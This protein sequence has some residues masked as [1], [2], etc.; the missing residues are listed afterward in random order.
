M[1][2]TRD[3]RAALCEHADADIAAF[4]TSVETGRVGVVHAS[5]G[6]GESR[7]PRADDTVVSYAGT[8]ARLHDHLDGPDWAGRDRARAGGLPAP[9]ARRRA[10][11]ARSPR[12]SRTSPRSATSTAGSPPTSASTSPRPTTTRPRSC[13]SSPT[14]W[15][16]Q[17]SGCRSP[18]P[19]G[20]PSSARRS[21]STTVSPSA[22]ATTSVC[23]AL[24]SSPSPRMPSTRCTGASSSST[25]RAARRRWASSTASWS[26]CC[27]TTD[28]RWP[29]APTSGSSSSS[30]YAR[31]RRGEA[32]LVPDQGVKDPGQRLRDALE[33]TILPNAGLAR[34]AFTP[35]SL[36]HSFGTNMAL[37]GMDIERIADQMS[38]STTE[39]T[40]RYV[41]AAGQIAA[42]RRRAATPIRA[43]S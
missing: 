43:V 13:A 16:G 12:R 18:T 8:L 20:S 41:N 21:P 27:R 7:R 15:R 30:R 37:A 19:S 25:A 4:L 9:A 36:R 42:W 39:T 6:R 31:S 35:H 38:H 3:E 2:L 10:G 23:D 29:T 5:G 11:R 28:R 34:D 33:G 26:A 32:T 22:S 14:A 17:P 40:L 1:S 24:R